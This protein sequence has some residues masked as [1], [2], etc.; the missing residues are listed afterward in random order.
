MATDFG[1]HTYFVA[2]CTGILRGLPATIDRSQRV[3][4]RH[5]QASR[6]ILRAVMP[7]EMQQSS[8]PVF[9]SHV[10]GNYGKLHARASTGHLTARAGSDIPQHLR[11]YPLP[12]Q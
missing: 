7:D 12:A 1:Q 8:S 10:A 11:A 2:I 6:E 5:R 3:M 9:K 4:A